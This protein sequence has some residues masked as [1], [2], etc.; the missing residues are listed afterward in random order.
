MV[1]C[2]GSAALRGRKAVENPVELG[3]HLTRTRVP[4]W[5]YVL[6]GI[7]IG[8]TV[9]GTGIHYVVLGVIYDGIYG[10]VGERHEPA[11]AA[12]AADPGGEQ[13]AEGEDGEL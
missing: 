9:E 13:R 3:G 6:I 4:R 1:A 8:L 12:G 10:G 7:F 5:C 11:A 2:T